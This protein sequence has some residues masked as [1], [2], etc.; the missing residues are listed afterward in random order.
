MKGGAINKTSNGKF[1]KDPKRDPKKSGAKGGKKSRL[2]VKEKMKIKVRHLQNLKYDTYEKFMT[3]S[4]KIN[5]IDEIAKTIL[6]GEEGIEYFLKQDV[7]LMKALSDYILNEKDTGMLD[8][9]DILQKRSYFIKNMKEAM[10]GTK[11]RQEVKTDLNI[12]TDETTKEINDI[13]ER[14]KKR[15]EKHKKSTRNSKR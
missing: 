12:S 6:A 5:N 4:G 15:F 1:G 10:Y 8:K 2:S 9:M 3:G 7:S 13:Y 14:T 11:S